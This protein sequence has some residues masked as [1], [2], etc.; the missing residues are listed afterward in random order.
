M[1][2]NEFNVEAE[3]IKG[4]GGI[5]D[6]KVD[7]KLIYSKNITGLFPTEDEIRKKMK[8]IG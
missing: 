4:C 8:E 6:V 7:G 5:F 2:R 3:L 1:L